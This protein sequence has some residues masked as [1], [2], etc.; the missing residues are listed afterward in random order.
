M[1]NINIAEHNFISDLTEEEQNHVHGG[2]GLAFSTATAYENFRT[3]DAFVSG[4]SVAVVEKG[5]KLESFEAIN[6][7]S[8]F[9]FS[10]KFR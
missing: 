6:T 9:R 10:L 2:L 1:T 7:P 8:G 3:G 5:A 4:G